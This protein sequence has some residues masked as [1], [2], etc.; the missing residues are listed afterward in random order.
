MM[1]HPDIEAFGRKVQ[2]AQRKLSQLRGEGSSGGVR[3]TVDATGKLLSVETDQ[4]AHIIA[5]YEAAIASISDQVESAT[6][7]VN[8]DPL[9]Q[10]ITSLVEASRTIK[11]AAL[12]EQEDADDLAFEAMRRD[13]LGWRRR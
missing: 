4:E 11:Q 7:A 1:D 2:E 13:P 9:T 5:A 3:V 12:I 8:D 6:R 10:T